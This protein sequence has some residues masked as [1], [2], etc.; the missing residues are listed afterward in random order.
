MSVEMLKYKPSVEAASRAVSQIFEV[1]IET[2]S[3]RAPAREAIGVDLQRE[4][5]VWLSLLFIDGYSVLQ[6]FAT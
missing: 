4:F 3:I 2:S 6:Y 1:P 5:I